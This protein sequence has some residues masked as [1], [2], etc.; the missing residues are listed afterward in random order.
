VHIDRETWNALDLLAKDRMQDFQELPHEAFADLLR[1]HGRP[2]DLKTALR[3]TPASAVATTPGR[4]E[5]G[6][7]G[8]VRASWRCGHGGLAIKPG[9]KQHA[10]SRGSPIASRSR[11]ADSVRKGQPV[12]TESR[13]HLLF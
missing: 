12:R 11:R 2:V 7:Q 1:K 13:H 8:R 6:T 5:E 10:G 9:D 3:Q 4:I